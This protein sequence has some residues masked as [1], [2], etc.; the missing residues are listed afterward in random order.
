MKTLCWACCM[1]VLSSFCKCK[2]LKVPLQKGCFEHLCW[3]YLPTYILALRKE[4][5]QK[6]PKSVFRV[7]HFYSPFLAIDDTVETLLYRYRGGTY[8]STAETGTCSC[9]STSAQCKTRIQELFPCCSRDS[10]MWCWQCTASVFRR[11]PWK[12]FRLIAQK[13]QTHFSRTHY[14]QIISHFS[15]I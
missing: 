1:P 10:S 8:H 4:C 15:C 7:S 11:F 9:S 12:G 13:A 14:F 5:K 6:Y 3:M 2:F